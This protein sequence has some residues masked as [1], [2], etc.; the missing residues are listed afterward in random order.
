MGKRFLSLSVAIVG[1][2]VVLPAWCA[3][4][5]RSERPANTVRV[6]GIVLADQ[7]FPVDPFETL[8]T[9]QVLHA[10]E[11]IMPAIVGTDDVGKIHT[12]LLPGRR[13]SARRA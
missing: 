3:E 11:S 1:L 6:A 8:L 9:Y 10:L 5:T 13:E 12:Q 4:Q 2:W 7:H